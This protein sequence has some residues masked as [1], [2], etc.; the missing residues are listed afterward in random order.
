MGVGREMGE[1]A[2]VGSSVA[3]GVGSGTGSSRG[4]RQ[5]ENISKKSPMV[6]ASLI[7]KTHRA[8]VRDS[9]KKRNMGP[10]LT[11]AGRIGPQKK[12]VLCITP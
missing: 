11:E 7:I 1:G 4:G 9:S 8:L 6:A 5:A 2:G 3:V 10:K 12:V